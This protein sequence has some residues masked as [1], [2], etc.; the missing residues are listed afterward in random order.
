MRN[1]MVGKK[2]CKRK[3]RA[4]KK[5]LSFWFECGTNDETTDRN[6][7]GIIDSIED[8]LELIDELHLIGYSKE[9]TAY[10]EVENGEHNFDTWK[11]VFSD[12]LDWTLKL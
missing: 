9:S 8:T 4:L 2:G 5:D 12:F 10:V 1:S 11:N 3:S 6:N 7:N